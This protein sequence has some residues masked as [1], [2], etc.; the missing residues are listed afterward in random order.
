[1]RRV[2]TWAVVGFVMALALAAVLTAA[3]RRSDDAST[4]PDTA[5]A[6]TTLALARCREGQLAL[7]SEIVGGDASVVLRH[8]S[9][10]P[11]D[12]G[13]LTLSVTVRDRRGER[14]PP[15]STTVGF[16][17]EISPD[18]DIIAPFVYLAWCDQKPPLVA[19]IRAGDLVTTRRVGIQACEDRNYRPH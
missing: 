11:C 16:S 14:T 10:P 15:Q 9:G 8:V 12:L 13:R 4:G 2:L 1:M 5:A 7:T 6:A 3:L 18:L 19:E 17:G